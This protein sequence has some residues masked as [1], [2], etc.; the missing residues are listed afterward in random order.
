M[1]C[2][3]VYDSFFGNTE[4]IAQA[5]GSSLGPKEDVAICRVTDVSTEQLNGLS[6]L[7]VGSPTRGFRPTKAIN[8]FLDKIPSGSLKN[9]NVLAFDTR[10]SPADVN[11]RVYSFLEKFFGYAAKPIAEKLK[12]KGGNL[13]VPPE[14]FFVKDSEGPLKDG[15]LE[16]AAKWAGDIHNGIHIT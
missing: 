6:L 3:I 5:I 16:R 9:I 2:L 12:K 13:L 15:E 7:I 11:S 10:I 1:K 4:Q 8:E 14:G